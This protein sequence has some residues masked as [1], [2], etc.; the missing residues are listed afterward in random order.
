MREAVAV[1]R[2][3]EG[4]EKKLVGYV[5]KEGEEGIGEMELRRYMRELV[6]EY[7]VPSEIVIMEEMPLTVNGKV[8]RGALPARDGARPQLEQGYVAPRNDTE[9]QLAA[10][11]RNVL[12]VKD[13]GIN[14]SFFDL[15][16]HSLLG[17]QLISEVTER[18][19]VELPLS[20]LFGTPTIEGLSK[21]ISNAVSTASDTQS[22]DIMPVSRDQY[23]I[24]ETVAQLS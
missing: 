8:D 12:E 14:D 1:V 19:G 9:E 22:P 16:G 6:P 3:G 24:K 5:V 15:G 21:A 4:G 20:A 2:E 7:M 17:I 13:V 23:R 11:W 10:I 18:F